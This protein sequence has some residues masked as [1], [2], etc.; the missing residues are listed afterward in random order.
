VILGFFPEQFFGVFLG[1]RRFAAEHPGDFVHAFGFCQFHH[2]RDRAVALRLFEH[3]VVMVGK[4]RDLVQ[5]RNTQKLVRGTQGHERLAHLFREHPA[6]TESISSKMRIGIRSCDA[7]TV[8][9]ASMSREI[10]PPDAIF[11]SGKI[12]S[13]V[14]VR[15]RKAASSRPSAAGDENEV[16]SVRHRPP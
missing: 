16:K 9:I 15:T 12:C 14:F 8:L 5:M 3:V 13:P 1:Y 7:M 4:R 2:K 11:T 6:D 10:S